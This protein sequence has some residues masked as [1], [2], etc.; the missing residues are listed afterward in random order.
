MNNVAVLMST[1]NGE[2]YLK[3]QI[4]SIFKQ[5]KVNIKL[6]IRDDGSTDNTMAI[7]NELKMVYD[8]VVINNSIE[9]MGPAKSFM[10][11]VYNVEDTFDFYAFSDQ[12]D[13]WENNKIISAIDMIKK[14]DDN[15]LYILFYLLDNI[16]ICYRLNSI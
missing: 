12:D 2:K 7:I 11:L 6:Y 4:E 14:H 13:I 1:Y 10:K 15:N 16:I 9:N 8:I 5:E 3:E